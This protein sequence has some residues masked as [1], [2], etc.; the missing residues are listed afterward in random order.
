M[1]DDSLSASGALPPAICLMGPTACGKTRIA[2]ELAQNGPFEIISVDSALVYKGLDIGSGK[3]DSA[4]LARAPHRLINIRDPS[5]PYSAAEFRADAIREM[6]DIVARGKLPLL[7]GGT[8]LYFKVLRDGLAA[9]P[10]AT[11]VIRQRIL[12]LATAEGWTAVHARLQ[13][14]DPQA[15]ARIHPNDPQR[16]QRALEVYEATGVPLSA[17]HAARP[18]GQTA[19]LPCELVFVAML[20]AQRAQLHQKISDRFH[21]M[22]AAGLI[23]EVAALKQRSDLHA[24]LPSIRSVGYRQV[25][26]YLDGITDYDTMIGKGIAATRQLAKRQLTWLRSWPAL[27]ELTC[28][29]EVEVED[30]TIVKNYLKNR[31]A[32]AIYW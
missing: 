4:T 17:L 24:D 12:D 22:L 30:E 25:W 28:S 23:E 14:V 11:P 1:G 32:A 18:L 31:T 5:Q 26:E 21:A 16:L 10:S 3:P 29:L 9:M 13:Q 7:V 20:P 19:D 8:M 2:V 6:N 27:H 15:A